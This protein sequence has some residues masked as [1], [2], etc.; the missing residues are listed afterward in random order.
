MRDSGHL[1]LLL[2]HQSQLFKTIKRM[3]INHRNWHELQT[4]VAFLLTKVKNRG[5]NAVRCI[6]N[7]GLFFSYAFF[8]SNKKK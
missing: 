5:K 4:N 7:R 6:G 3:C 8:A 2:R 1:P